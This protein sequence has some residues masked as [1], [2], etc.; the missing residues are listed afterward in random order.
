M[1]AI[2]ALVTAS[3]GTAVVVAHRAST[4]ARSEI[5][6]SQR[7]MTLSTALVRD[8]RHSDRIDVRQTAT[9]VVIDITDHDG[10]TA[11]YRES[12]D[13]STLA[14]WHDGVTDAM[15][16]GLAPVAPNSPGPVDVTLDARRLSV[17][18]HFG[19]GT[20]MS[21]TAARQGTSP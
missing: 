16:T 14:R 11:T 15:V 2:T 3:A 5:E 12:F 20:S 10:A 18:L 19:D 6:R 17:V 1:L 8:V 7:V 13:E 4:T 9:G 21:V